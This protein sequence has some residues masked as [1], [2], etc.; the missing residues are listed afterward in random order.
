MPPSSNVKV[1]IAASSSPPQRPS[2]SN[3]AR[4]AEGPSH[5][6]QHYIAG[7]MTIGVAIGL[8]IH[9][10]KRRESFRKRRSK[11]RGYAKSVIRQGATLPPNA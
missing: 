4:Q 7:R 10:I 9:S 6:T 11:I 1:R 3:P 8:V 5:L 2:K